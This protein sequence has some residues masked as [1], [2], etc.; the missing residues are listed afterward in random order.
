MTTVA[1]D[2]KE[3]AAWLRNA[4]EL[5]DR[6]KRY[7]L[8]GSFPMS[9]RA[10]SV[11]RYYNLENVGDLLDVS[12]EQMGRLK[13]CGIQTRDEFRALLES[14]G[15]RPLSDREIREELKRLRKAAGEE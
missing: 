13:N 6:A 11:T 15:L 3:Y 5:P 7:L 4:K 9:T 2:K 8:L 14:I 10:W 12:W 1:A